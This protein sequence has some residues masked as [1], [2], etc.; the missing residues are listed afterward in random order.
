MGAFSMSTAEHEI[1]TL[2]QVI[3]LMKDKKSMA[4][5][6]LMRIESISNRICGGRPEIVLDQDKPQ[7]PSQLP[8]AAAMISYMD[9]LHGV[10]SSIDSEVDRLNRSVGAKHLANDSLP[11]NDTRANMNKAIDW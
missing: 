4:H 8:M 1:P 2:Q 11:S 5:Q 9:Q 3:E 6:I 7:D 10:L